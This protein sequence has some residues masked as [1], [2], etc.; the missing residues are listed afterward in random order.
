M[1]FYWSWDGGKGPSEF[2][3]ASKAELQNIVNQFCEMLERYQS[4]RSSLPNHLHLYIKRKISETPLDVTLPVLSEC[5]LKASEK[6]E[7][8]IALTSDIL[9]ILIEKMQK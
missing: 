5:A 4:F 2:K 9:S 7:C 6:H 1:K 8:C 3:Q